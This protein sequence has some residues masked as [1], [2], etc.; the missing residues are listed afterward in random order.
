MAC[1]CLSSAD[2]F[3]TTFL[4]CQHIV[5]ITSLKLALA[6][7]DSVMWGRGQLVIL[8]LVI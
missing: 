6:T 3:Q 7:A 2:E 5:E 4:F 8:S 1:I